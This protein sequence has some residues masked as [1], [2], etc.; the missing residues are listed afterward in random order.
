MKKNFPAVCRED[1]KRNPKTVS[2]LAEGPALGCAKRI[3]IVHYFRQKD[4]T[5]SPLIFPSLEGKHFLGGQL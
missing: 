3:V 1:K 4:N 2:F 5:F